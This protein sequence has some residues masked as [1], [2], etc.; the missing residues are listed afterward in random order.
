M[1]GGQDKIKVIFHK[2]SEKKNDDK[3][4]GL[5]RK[6]QEISLSVRRPRVRRRRV[7]EEEEEVLTKCRVQR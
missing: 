1:L 5:G 2:F 6:Q 7:E 4:I 3:S